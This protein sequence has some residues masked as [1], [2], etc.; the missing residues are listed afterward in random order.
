MNHKRIYCRYDFGEHKLQVNSCPVKILALQLL[1][2]KKKVSLTFFSLS[3]LCAIK[4]TKN[5]DERKTV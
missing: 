2:S 4:T 3:D 1:E 5:L